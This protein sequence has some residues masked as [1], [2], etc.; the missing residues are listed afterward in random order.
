MVKPN[1]SEKTSDHTKQIIAGNQKSPT[2]SVKT[3]SD[4]LNQRE[5]PVDTSTKSENGTRTDLTSQRRETVDI[6]TKSEKG[7]N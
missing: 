3:T 7:A 1:K 2:K 4:Q 6:P 5:N